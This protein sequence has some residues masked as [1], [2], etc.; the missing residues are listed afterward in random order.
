M[1][2]FEAFPTVFEF[3]YF[4]DLSFEFPPFFNSLGFKGTSILLWLLT[5][6]LPLRG[7]PS[8]SSSPLGIR[9]SLRWVKSVAFGSLALGGVSRREV[10]VLDRFEASFCC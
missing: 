2:G 10:I 5:F 6:L 7:G 1:Q 8:A 4:L 9:G 3:F